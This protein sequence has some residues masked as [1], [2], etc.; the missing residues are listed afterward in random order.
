MAMKGSAFIHLFGSG[1]D[2]ALLNCCGVDHKV[3]RRLL[4]IFQPVFDTYTVDRNTMK[5]RP[6]LFTKNG[7][8]K[9]N[10][11]EITATIG[12]A[13]VLTWFRTRGSAARTLSM[14]FGLTSTPLYKWLKYSRKVLLYVL[15]N[16]P[17]AIIRPPSDEEVEAYVAAIGRKYEAL[18]TKRVW[19][20][21]D[22]LKVK[23]QH[24]NN[25]AI[26]SMYYNSW[27]CDTYINS[28]LVFAPDGRIRMTTY[29]CPGTWHDSTMAEYGVY[30]KMET[31][32]ERTGGVVVVD[33][34]F[35]MK[36][37]KYLIRS[38]QNDPDTI[39]TSMAENAEAIVINRQ[40]TAVRQLSE[41][42]MRMIQGQ[43]PRMKD[44]LTLEELGDRKIILNL[45]LLLYN[46]QCSAVG[47]NQILNTFMSNT[48]GFESFE[49]LR[50]SY[51]ER[52][53][54]YFSYETT[55]AEDANTEFRFH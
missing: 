36:G 12:L 28:V 32:Y 18:G 4:A 53:I 40:A 39:T 46:Y 1:D 29:N 54:G 50:Q 14:V 37:S 21:A 15:Q 45:L 55:P 47:I 11:R 27:V 8:P 49:E 42:G 3:F 19:G 41:W 26:Q 6:R 33:S 9:G 30:E 13:V 31:I 5:V 16:H 52:Q 43:F 17:D 23:L 35:K 25:W 10:K 20:A 7:K 24:S 51:G 44:R 2:Q 38:Q 22:G 34:A 48:S